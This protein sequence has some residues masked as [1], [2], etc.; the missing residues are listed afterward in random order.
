MSNFDFSAA[1]VKHSAWKIKL[2]KFLDHNEGLTPQQASSH[3]DCELGKW[4][5]GEA[6]TKY[7][8]VPEMAVLEREHKQLHATVKT[9]V[10]FKSAG[11]ATAA[12]AEYA[13]IETLSQRIVNLLTT[14][15]QKVSRKAA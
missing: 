15:E 7:K 14:I 1:R 2:R 11:N 8:H 10:D 3:H 13:K 9:I 12:E 6:L 4:L 5:Y